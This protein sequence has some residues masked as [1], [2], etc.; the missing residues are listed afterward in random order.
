MGFVLESDDNKLRVEFGKDRS[1]TFLMREEAGNL[2][3]LRLLTQKEKRAKLATSR[4]DQLTQQAKTAKN[5]DEYQ[6]LVKEIEQLAN[7]PD[8]ISV[9]IDMIVAGSQGWTDFFATKADEEA[10]RPVEFTKASIEKLPLVALKRISEAFVAHY[11]LGAEEPGEAKGSLQEPSQ[12]T[13]VSSSPT[14]TS[15][16]A[17]TAP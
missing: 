8:E 5:N 10:G 7:E 6:K 9:V 3:A 4:V 14:G 12:L 13:G 1:I 2:P 17:T 16:S 11:G 15:T